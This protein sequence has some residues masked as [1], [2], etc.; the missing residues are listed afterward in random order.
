MAYIPI[1]I[2]LPIQ[3]ITLIMEQASCAKAIISDHE[4]EIKL[5]L[6]DHGVDVVVLNDLNLAPPGSKQTLGASDLV[7]SLSA[8]NVE[9]SHK[10]YTIFTSGTTGVPKGVVISHGAAMNTIADVI[11][12]WSLTSHDVTFGISKLNFDLSVFDIFGPLSIGGAV[13]LPPANCKD[14]ETWASL[15]VKH[16][17]S[18]WNSVPMIVQM[19]I[20]APN[21]L[22]QQAWKSLKL[23]MLSGDWIPIPLARKLLSLREAASGAQAAALVSLG[24]ATEASIWSIYHIIEPEDVGPDAKSIPYGRPLANQQ[25]HIAILDADGNWLD[26][27]PTFATGQLFI[28]GQGLADGYTDP[29]KTTSAFINHPFTGERLYKTGDLARYLG[30]GEIEFIGR[31]DTQVKIRGHRIELDE[32]QHYLE[33]VPGVERAAA[34][35]ESDSIVGALVMTF[36]GQDV[37]RAQPCLAQINEI[38]ALHLPRYMLVDHVIHLDA[39]PLSANGKVDVKALSKEAQTLLASKLIAAH[40]DRQLQLPSTMTE[41]ALAKIWNE[42]LAMDG[43]SAIGTASCFFELGGHSLLAIRLKGAIE[44]GFG[45]I[46]TLK[47]LFKQPCR[48]G[49]IAQ[50]ID[51]LILQMPESG[52]ADA[53]ANFTLAHASTEDLDPY[54]PFPLTPIQAAYL[55][56]RGDQLD[57]GGVSAHSYVEYRLPTVF[58]ALHGA[59]LMSRV[60]GRIVDQLVAR[61]DALRLVF[62]IASQT[63]RVLRNDDVPAYSVRSIDLREES[64][65]EVIQASIQQIRDEMEALVLDAAA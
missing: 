41:V 58:V 12:K 13:V 61:H 10:A 59:S 64:D 65:E 29:V 8:K 30:N 4:T 47:E 42:I 25:M 1:E 55:L 17:V 26:D 46:V 39:L 52:K 9:P 62:D 60:V 27:A 38:L 22:I 16:K 50:T 7:K 11:D 15:V 18:I 63:Q 57:L 28:S 31:S 21:E 3:R 45:V 19:L 53:D 37:P 40:S 44:R 32:I 6:Q 48:L 49:E 43:N 2:D 51:Q 5:K 24:G 14:P 23:V 36:R 35:V 33:S 54:A 56:G 34:L 20:E